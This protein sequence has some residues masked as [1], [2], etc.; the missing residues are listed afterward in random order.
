[1]SSTP[2]LD[3]K[4]IGWKVKVTAQ[5]EH[6]PE[7]FKLISS[8]RSRS[9]HIIKCLVLM[10]KIYAVYWLSKLTW[11]CDLKLFSKLSRRTRF[12]LQ[13]KA[14]ALVTVI[15]ESKYLRTCSIF[16]LQVVW[17]NCREW[18]VLSPCEFFEVIKQKVKVTEKF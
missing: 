11:S 1:M 13:Q 2:L 17:E 9:H 4:V 18:W 16:N 3:F 14:S 7:N 15:F 12:L 8:K 6:F 5:F 10:W